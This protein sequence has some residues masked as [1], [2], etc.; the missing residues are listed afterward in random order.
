[1]EELA[2]TGSCKGSCKAS[3]KGSIRVPIIRLEGFYKVRRF[4]PKLR[5]RSE[6]TMVTQEA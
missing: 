4:V 3:C 2:S 1:M 5:I 6:H